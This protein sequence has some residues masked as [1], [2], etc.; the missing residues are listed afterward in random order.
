MLSKQ[1]FRKY[2]VLQILFFVFVVWSAGGASKYQGYLYSPNNFV[3]VP[4]VAICC[5]MLSKERVSLLSRDLVVITIFLLIWGAIGTSAMGYSC[6]YF[7]LIYNLFLAYTICNVY[8][9]DMFVLYENVVTI[10]SL[11]SLIAFFTVLAIPSFAELLKSISINKV[12]GLWESNVLLF[13]IQ[14]IDY[15]TAILFSRRNLG[16]AWEPGR[17]AVIV[18]IALY[19]NLVINKFILKG[20]QNF[21]ILFTTLITTQSTTGYGAAMGVV[22]LYFYN[23]RYKSAIVPIGILIFFIFSSLSFMNEKI[24]TLWN[25]QQNQSIHFDNQMMYYADNEVNYVPQRFEGIYYDILNFLHSPFW[26]YGSDFTN[27][28]VNTVMFQGARIYASDGIIQIF[29]SSGILVAFFLYW[30]LFRSSTMISKTLGYKGT[31]LFVTMFLL[32]NISYNFWMITIY[33][34]MI[35]FSLFYHE[36]TEYNNSNV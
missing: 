36:E 12:S 2:S 31:L 14:Q 13:G 5:L 9:K 1:I 22:L 25:W 3:A 17:F 28:Y 30:L 32:V 6:H 23:S 24:L 10:F 16:F 27:S 34:S 19:F 20:N 4:I 11:I 8:K 18:V 21:W 15:D 35:L 7:Y 33:T 29:S 26:G